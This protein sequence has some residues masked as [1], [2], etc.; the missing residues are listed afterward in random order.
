MGAP[1]DFRD[2]EVALGAVIGVGGHGAT[3][4]PIYNIGENIFFG[5]QLNLARTV[6]TDELMNSHSVLLL[7]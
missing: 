5:N 4:Q 1:W 7:G 2:A 3:A 6:F